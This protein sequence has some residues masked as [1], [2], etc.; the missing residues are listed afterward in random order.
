MIPLVRLQ[1]DLQAA[2]MLVRDQ[3]GPAWNMLCN[4]AAL[5]S[6]LGRRGEEGGTGLLARLELLLLQLL[7]LARKDGLRRRRGV[8]AGGL[9]GD[10]EKAAVLQKVLRVDADDAGLRK[11]EQV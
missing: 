8:D 1:R 9:D 10:D 5:G 3:S 2:A 4:D 6:E 11:W 7:D